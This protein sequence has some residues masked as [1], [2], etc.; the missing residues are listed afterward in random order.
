M[1]NR[2]GQYDAM[3]VNE[4]LFVAGLVDEFDR[5]VRARDEQS[6]KRILRDVE[7]SDDNIDAILKQVLPGR[8]T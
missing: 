5:A 8:G 6:L 3:T 2:V 1:Q 7:V 4:R